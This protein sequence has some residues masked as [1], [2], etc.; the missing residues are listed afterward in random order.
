MAILIP[1]MSFAADSSPRKK[2][3]NS[4]TMEWYYELEAYDNPYD[5]SYKVKVWSYAPTAKT[6]R[7]QAMKNAVHGAIFRGVPGNPDKRIVAMSPLVAD[8]ALEQTYGEFFRK[9]FA[10]GGEYLRYAVRTFSSGN[11]EV[12]KYGYRNYKVGVV[13]TIQ[14]DELRKRLEEEGIIRSLSSGFVK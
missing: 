3:A 14:Y 9:F 8:M 4:N 6:A 7:D 10:D 13:V 12:V 11:N 5:G 1:A 2:K